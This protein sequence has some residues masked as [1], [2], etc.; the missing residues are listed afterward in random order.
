MPNDRKSLFTSSSK[1]YG[2]VFIQV[3][4]VL[5]DISCSFIQSHLFKCRYFQLPLF[6]DFPHFGCAV[7]LVVILRCNFWC[8]YLF[9]LLQSQFLC[10]ERILSGF[11]YL[12]CV[13]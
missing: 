10:G 13:G 1:V 5:P 11:N 3:H 12:L 8:V 7:A 6:F 2:M 4:R 9:F